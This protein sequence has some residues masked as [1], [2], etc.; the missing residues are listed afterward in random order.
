[1]RLPS[2][3]A[4]LI[5]EAS[6]MPGPDHFLT[7]LAAKLIP[8]PCARRRCAHIGV[9]TSDYRATRLATAGGDA[10]VIEALGSGPSVRP[11]PE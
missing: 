5:D 7:T 10:A 2:A 11:G 9:A 1:M 4:W 8:M 3:L 6:T